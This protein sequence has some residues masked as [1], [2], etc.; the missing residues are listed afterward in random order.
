MS[1]STKMALLQYGLS[2]KWFM[3]LSF[4]F[5]IALWWGRCTVV[6]IKQDHFSNSIVN[7]RVLEVYVRSKSAFQYRHK[8]KLFCHTM[9]NKEQ[10]SVADGG[11][12]FMFRHSWFID[13]LNKFR[14][15]TLRRRQEGMLYVL[16]I[17]ALYNKSL[18]FF[19]AL[20][21]ERSIIRKFLYFG[22]IDL[23][24]IIFENATKICIC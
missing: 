10:E 21:L 12:C 4:V 14:Q 7:P 19:F 15:V 9:I 3:E 20:Q 5:H 22:G 1:L 13:F 6:K 16:Q 8:S 11:H 17:Q 18:F 24:K 2:I 23:P